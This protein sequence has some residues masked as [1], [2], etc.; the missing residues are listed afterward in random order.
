MRKF[1]QPCSFLMT[2]NDG[3]D[4]GCKSLRIVNA[5]LT[6]LTSEEYLMIWD[7]DEIFQNARIFNNSNSIDI[8]KYLKNCGHEP[9]G[10]F[11]AQPETSPKPESKL[12]PY[13]LQPQ[14]D[15]SI[16]YSHLLLAS[17]VSE[18]SMASIDFG[19]RCEINIYVQRV[20]VA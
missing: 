15:G 16:Y 13:F 19:G 2:E 10:R 11:I 3:Y 18:R 1:S 4:E 7:F 20:C 12:L 9:R 5:V 14:L 17:S 6:M 8:H